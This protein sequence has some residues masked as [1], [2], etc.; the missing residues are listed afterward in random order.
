MLR[1]ALFVGS[2]SEG[3]R[4]AETIQVLLDPV[5]EVELWTQGVFGLTQGTLESLV[6]ASS[7]FDFALLVL[8]ADDLVISRSIEKASPRDNVLFEFGLFIGSL[9]RERTFM[10]YDRTNTPELPSDL[11]G[12]TAATFAPHTSGNLEAALGAPST[13]IRNM[14]ELRGV[15][16][17]K[18]LRELEKTVQESGKLALTPEDQ[19]SNARTTF[20]F[21]RASADPIDAIK[22]AW[23]MVRE[24][25]QDVARRRG[26]AWKT[27]KDLTELLAVE[28]LLDSNVVK[29]ILDLRSLRYHMA[30]R[31]QDDLTSST[32]T[33]YI[34]AAANVA[35]NLRALPGSPHAAT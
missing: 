35:D 7:R 29:L 20:L 32:A 3:Q 2:S 30:D 10:L 9:G 33:A 12:I 34:S 27:T 11:A 4:I 1:P 14:I 31:D 22:G 19:I 16:K 24:A 15:R 28:G 25:A 26:V 18:S 21:R 23:E 17:E 8:T 5:C 13:R 6:N